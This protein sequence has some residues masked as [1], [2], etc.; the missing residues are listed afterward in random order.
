ML[1]LLDPR[2]VRI[3]NRPNELQ[4]HLCPDDAAKNG[5]L[6]CNDVALGQSAL[7]PLGFVC[8]GQEL[9]VYFYS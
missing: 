8:C 7:Q 6:L 3:V 1:A 9:R 4:V 5:G 2:A